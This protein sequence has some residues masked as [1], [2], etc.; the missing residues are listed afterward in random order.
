[1]AACPP[2]RFPILAR[3]EL[4]KRHCQYR[5]RVGY[6]GESSGAGSSAPVRQSCITLAFWLF[7][8]DE[9]G[10]IIY[11]YTTYQMSELSVGAPTPFEISAFNAPEA[12]SFEVYATP[13]M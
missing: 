6:A 2:S 3:S 7:L 1:M 4:L 9:S 5:A 11:G 12:A 10:A 8:S 13:W